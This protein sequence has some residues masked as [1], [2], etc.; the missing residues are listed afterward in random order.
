MH[1]VA[2]DNGITLELLLQDGLFLGIGRVTANGVALRKGRRPM[3]V[4]IR[5][6]YAVALCDYTI[7]DRQ[8]SGDRLRLDFTMQ[9]KEGGIMEWMLHA[10]RNRY[11]TADW[12]AQPEPA[13]DTRLRLEIEAVNRVIGA[14]GFIGYRYQYHYTSDSIPIYKILDR[15]TWEIGGSAI[16][17]QIWMRQ[18]NMPPI[19]TV[20][21]PEAWYSTEWYLPIVDNPN[22]FQFFPLQTQLQGFTFTVARQGVLVTW[23]T[24][25]AHVRTLIEKRRGSDE[26]CHW[27]E[28]CGDLGYEFVTAPVEVLWAPGERDRVECINL[29]ED[30]RAL[31]WET[32]HRQIGMRQERVTTYGVIEEWEDPDFDYYIEQGLPK[33]LGAGV[34]TIFIPNQFEN[35]MNTWGVSNMCC[36]VDY[37]VAATVG[38]DRLKRFCDVV[39]AAG[40]RVEMWGNTS[41]STLTL[42]F[43]KRNGR[44][45]G[46][47]FLP[48]EGSIMEALE[49]AEEPWVRNPSN[50]IETD[51][52][53]PVFAVMNLRDPVVRD[54]WHRAWKA[55][56]DE[57]GIEVIF[58]DSS[59]NLSSDKFH[60]RANT[61]SA[62]SGATIDQTQL[63]GHCRPAVEPEAAIRSQY[64]AHLDLMV[65]MQQY[66][67]TY[68]GE[69]TGVFGISRSGPDVTFRLDNLFMW[70][71]SLT[72]FDVPA[73]QAAGADPDA[74]FFQ[75]L[76]YRMMWMIHW[77][78]RSNQL[79]FRYGGFRGECDRPTEWHLA[80]LR[81]FNQVNDLMVNRTV[82]PGERGVLYRSGGRQVLWAFA[83][84]A[85]PLAAP[86][87]VQELLSGST[88]QTGVLEAERHRVYLI[89]SLISPPDG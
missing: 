66:G 14:T 67:Y 35:N 46:I 64:R 65:E 26:I 75:G 43:D 87:R 42:I 10:V 72:N 13:A 34:K 45:K 54:Y 73:I 47:R 44:P 40:A 7:A 71:E 16:G 63:L 59:F 17:N 79:S 88:A 53:T 78:I 55:A 57:I 89:E 11:N 31:V 20:E 27:H 84:F 37:K 77:D 76:A 80:L 61:R 69:D 48:R 8:V 5:N 25:V 83:D 2:F 6:P 22:I 38:A 39:R 9:R 82:L 74:V 12:T 29:Y 85:L 68:C 19:Y 33:L 3:F 81:V 50:A 24:E 23:P 62:R 51:H 56:H 52:Y 49:R 41:V 21:S 58:L 15:G 36:T 86:S 1:S 32:L 4:E 30:V 18:G 28:H 70:V 60:F